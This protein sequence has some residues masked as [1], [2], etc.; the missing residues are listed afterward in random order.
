LDILKRRG[1]NSTTLTGTDLTAL[2][3]WHQHPKV[4]GMKKDVK[5]VTWMEIKRL[6]TAPP[7]FEKWTHKDN[8][9][10]KEAQ[11]NVVEMAHTSF[12]HLEALK[13]KEFL[14]AALFMTQE[15]FDNITADREKLIVELPSNNDRLIS[16]A[17]NELIVGAADNQNTCAVASSDTSGGGG[18]IMGGEKRV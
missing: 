4:A 17:P 1:E 18:G 14:L 10:L 12:G 2:L 16:D 6:R 11:S 9:K 5:F 7:A 15:E 3:T 8:E 13:K